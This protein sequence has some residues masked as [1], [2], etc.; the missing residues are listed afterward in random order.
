MNVQLQEKVRV[1]QL[2]DGLYQLSD[3]AL[4][5]A[6]EK[7]PEEAARLRKLLTFTKAKKRV[8]HARGL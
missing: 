7:Y 4:V 8:T 6:F 1:D 3:A 2:R 5:R